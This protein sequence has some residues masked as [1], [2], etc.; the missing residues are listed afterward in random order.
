[1]RSW[2]QYIL[3]IGLASLLVA[4]IGEFSDRK[5][6]TGTVIRMICGLF[7]AFTVLSPL[8]DLNFEI[9]DAFSRELNIDAATVIS[10]GNQLRAESVREL[11]KQE[12]EAYILDKAR[13]L[14]CTLT[15]AVTVSDA[16]VP[17]PVS[18]QITGDIS[19]SERRELEKFLE[20]ELGISK[21]NQ[22]WIG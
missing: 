17:V 3:S 4:I 13:W 15:A 14:G 11:I 2:G 22:Q 18:V 8:T 21:E 1:M 16:Q 6:S 10:T 7:L 19:A 9:L 20:Q 5:S 12:T